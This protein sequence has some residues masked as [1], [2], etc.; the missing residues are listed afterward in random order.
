MNDCFDNC[1]LVS[2][3]DQKDDNA[4]ED[5]NTS[6][7]GIQHYGDLCDPDFDNDGQV[8]LT[9]YAT[10]RMYYRQNVPP[11]PAYVDLD[12]DNLVGLSDYA[13]W[14]KYYRGVPGP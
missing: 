7:A 5:D 3:P 13:I 11:A 8:T 2:N 10:W 12:G 9:D 4:A 14:R 6:V 1:K